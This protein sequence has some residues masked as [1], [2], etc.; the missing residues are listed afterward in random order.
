MACL[1]PRMSIVVRHGS[2]DV[3]SLRCRLDVSVNSITHAGVLV[4]SLLL[5][6]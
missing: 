3:C 2:D 5:I 4:L 6:H 1:H